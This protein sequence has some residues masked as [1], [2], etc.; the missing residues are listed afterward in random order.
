MCVFRWPTNKFYFTLSCVWVDVC[1][2]VC[3]ERIKTVRTHLLILSAYIKNKQ[4]TVLTSH[5]FQSNTEKKIILL[6]LMYFS[7]LL[8]VI[9]KFSLP[10][11]KSKPK[12]KYVFF[13]IHEKPWHLL[14][15]SVTE[16]NSDVESL[17]NKCKNCIFSACKENFVFLVPTHTHI[18][19][20]IQIHNHI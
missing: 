3:W 12:Q 16:K 19:N 10:K 13:F 11:I 7:V 15:V 9:S 6:T 2:C 5:L 1:L 8:S 17:E 14:R 18:W 20:S 4:K